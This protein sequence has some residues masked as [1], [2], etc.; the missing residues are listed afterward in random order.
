M[1]R[2]MRR[3]RSQRRMDRVTPKGRH[4]IHYGRK[5]NSM[6]HCSICK[7]ELSGIS[8]NGKAKG[9][10]L[11]TN[12]RIFGGALCAKCTADVIKYASRVEHG[13]MKMSDVGIR[14]RAYILQ[15]L[16]H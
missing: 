6:P 11:K 8:R 12:S 2:P 5:A 9:R 16:S 4:V 3:S 15:M 14:Q 7:A 13:E 10:T 1:P